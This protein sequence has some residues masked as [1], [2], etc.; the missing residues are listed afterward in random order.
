MTVSH[1]QKT[2]AAQRLVASV[3][4]VLTGLGLGLALVA[5]LLAVIIVQVNQQGERAIRQSDKAFDQGQLDESTEFARQ[6]ATWYLPNARHVERAYERLT[7][8]ALGSEAKGD[9]SQAISAWSALRGVLHD[10]SHPWMVNETRSAV[11]NDH[12]ARLLIG[13]LPP[14]QV[15]QRSELE[16]VYHRSQPQIWLF[17]AFTSG[18]AALMLLAAFAQGWPAR[19]SRLLSPG[20]S[21]L[22]LG[23][24][25]LLWTVAAAGA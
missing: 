2:S 6:A 9:V 22:A 10:T 19:T 4:S 7:A 1:E 18:G 3:Q 15:E 23:L 16:Q 8:I 17:S 12:L 14:A 25:L 21:R 13:R 11:A 5:G 20:M 24:G